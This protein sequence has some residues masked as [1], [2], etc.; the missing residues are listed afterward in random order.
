MKKILLIT[1]L[2]L[3]AVLCFSQNQLG[4]ATLFQII[5][6]DGDDFPTETNMVW[7]GEDKIVVNCWF[8]DQEYSWQDSITSAYKRTM[9]RD[10]DDDGVSEEI[11]IIR[12]Y[13][14]NNITYAATYI[15][16]GL[17]MIS[18]NGRRGAESTI[19][20]DVDR[21]LTSSCANSIGS[22]KNTGYLLIRIAVDE[23]A[24]MAALM[25]AVAAIVSTAARIFRKTE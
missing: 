3:T 21:S 13:T 12:Y 10:I 1:I 5:R 6:V 14:D 9:T 23:I 25:P 7:V 24:E 16:N 4:V 20:A 11:K 22:E 17:V 18:T 2:L 19:P 8:Q 15:N